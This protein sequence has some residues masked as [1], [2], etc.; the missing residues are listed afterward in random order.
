MRF[1]KTMT[2]LPDT[3]GLPLVPLAGAS[4]LVL[5]VTGLAAMQRCVS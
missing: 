1:A 4:L 3:G 2:P 5:G